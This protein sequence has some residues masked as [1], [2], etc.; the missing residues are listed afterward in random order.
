MDLFR[1]CTFLG[2]ESESALGYSNWVLA[3]LKALEAGG[4]KVEP[5][6][7]YIVEHMHGLTVAADSLTA[8]CARNPDNSVAQV[9]GTKTTNCFC[10]VELLSHLSIFLICFLPA[11]FILFFTFCST[12][13]MSF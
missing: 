6:N 3:T 2:P 5:H 11:Q 9:P 12:P 13:D 10:S 7:R 1:H 4:N 8:Y